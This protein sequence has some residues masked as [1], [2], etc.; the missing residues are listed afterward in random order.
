VSWAKLD[1]RDVI[2]PAEYPKAMKVRS[3]LEVDDVERQ[4][5]YEADWKQYD[6]WL[7]QE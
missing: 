2:G 3:L 6:E 4:R 7:R 5:I 1:Y